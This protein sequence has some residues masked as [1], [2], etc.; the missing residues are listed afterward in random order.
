MSY[1]REVF[2][3]SSRVSHSFVKGILD[4]TSGS[5]SATA[6]GICADA[7]THYLYIFARLAT[8]AVRRLAGQWVIGYNGVEQFRFPFSPG[9]INDQILSTEDTLPGGA[10]A[11]GGFIR[12]GWSLPTQDAAGSAT[13]QSGTAGSEKALWCR[14]ADQLISAEAA[15]TGH[16]LVFPYKITM[17]AT[18]IGLGISTCS[19]DTTAPQYIAW[20]VMSE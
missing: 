2:A 5:R 16:Q 12:V 7:S 15:L 17:P 19:L 8:S 18:E 10:S 14:H 6:S 3:A 20:A 4:L 1:N 13:Y 9:G 11:G